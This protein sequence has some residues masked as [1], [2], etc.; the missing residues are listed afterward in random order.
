MVGLA[1]WL[2]L[3]TIFFL[4]NHPQYITLLTDHPYA[5]LLAILL[6]LQV[7]LGV[8]SQRILTRR[9]T[10][11][12]GIRGVFILGGVLLLAIVYLVTFRNVIGLKYTAT[13]PAIFAFFFNSCWYLLL[14]LALALALFAVGNSVT[15][16]LNQHH[17]SPLLAIAVGFSLMAFLSTILGLIHGLYGVALGLVFVGAL[18]YQ[19]KPTWQLLQAW[20]VKRTTWKITHWWELPLAFTGLMIAAMYWL[21]S[22]KA[23]PIGFDGAALYANLAHLTAQSHTLPGAVQAFGWSVVMSWGELLFQSLT[24]SLLLAH[25]LYVPAL[26]MGYQISRRWLSP[27]YA[28][29]LMVLVASLPAIGFQ[30]MIDEKV[31]LALLFIGLASLQLVLNHKLD[32]ARRDTTTSWW[33]QPVWQVILLNGW[34]LGF[35][36]SIKYTAL[37]LVIAILAVYLFQLGRYLLFTGWLILVTGLLFLTGFYELGNLEIAPSAAQLLGLGLVAVG[38]FVLAWFWW[39]NRAL[40]RPVVLS[41]VAVGIGFVLAFMPW[42][43]KHLH[44][45]DFAVSLKH[46]LYGK[47]TAPALEIPKDL[48]SLRFNRAPRRQQEPGSAP[49]VK[50]TSN[51]QETVRTESAVPQEPVADNDNLIGDSKREE[52]QRYIGYEKGIN[53]YLSIP[54]DLT[55]NTNIKLLRYQETGFF[56]LALLP[57]LFLTFGSGNKRRTGLTNGLVGIGGALYLALCFWSLT[58]APDVAAHIAARHAANEADLS[59][60]SVGSQGFWLNLLDTCERP[61]LLIGGSLAPLWKSL[62]ELPALVYFPLLLGMLL[63]IPLILRHRTRQWPAE[64]VGLGAFCLAFGWYWL[65]LGNAITW[66]AMPL[67]VLLPIFLIYYLQQPELLLEPSRKKWSG[68]AFGG[69][70]MLQIGLNMA[71]LFSSSNA[72]QPA[73]V[74]F[75]WPMIEYVSRMDSDY[76]KTLRAFDPTVQQIAQIINADKSAKVF[77]VNSYLQ[78]HIDHNDQRVLEDNQLGRFAGMIRYLRNEN[79]FFQVLKANG[80]RYLLYD[81]NSPTLDQTPEQTLRKKCQKFLELIYQNPQQVTLVATDNYVEAPNAQPVKLPNGQLAAAK[82]ELAGKTIYPG[83]IALF[84]IN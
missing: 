5:K 37:F 75:N 84:K 8:G 49:F 34:L 38:G 9:K 17:R 24:F 14:L 54:F 44:E 35:S 69:V 6:V 26:L 48:L 79:E 42:G 21:A 40:F 4:G 74:L 22:L 46:V 2:F 23:F 71:I 32:E 10:V 64:L 63:V 45:H 65:L 59:A 52:L 56:L 19:R 51:Q 16:R 25:V 12:I 68:V 7:A 82:P 78:F 13:G 39:K 55:L 76:A 58:E 28:L 20:L 29:L 47:P 36:F 62:S 73:N 30:A 27:A 61:F 57:L 43:I 83:R 31:D 81:I 77:R 50:R 60:L 41:V 72:Q 1:V 67:W 15:Q 11:Q 18:Y 66:Y 33:R 3:I 80:F 53:R 70:M